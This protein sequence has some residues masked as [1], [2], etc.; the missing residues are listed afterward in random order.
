M[1]AIFPVVL[2]SPK[3]TEPIVL[4][5]LIAQIIYH[6]TPAIKAPA[7]NERKEKKKTA[8]RTGIQQQKCFDILYVGFSDV[9]RV[10]FLA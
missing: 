8:A 9:A 7:R 2:I 10:V 4:S 1:Y 5:A 6:E 3:L